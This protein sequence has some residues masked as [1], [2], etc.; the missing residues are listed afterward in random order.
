MVT[1]ACGGMGREIATSLARRGANV[2][3]VCRDLDRGL[4][5]RDAI[6][7][8]TGNSLVELLLADLSDQAAIHRIAAKFLERHDRLHVLI[9]NAGAHVMTRQLSVD[10][11]EMNLAVNHMSAFVLTD[12][13]LPT[14][15][16]SAPARIV[17]V[18]SRAMTKGIDLDNLNWDHDFAPW[19]AYGQAK[20]AM[21]LCSH[22]L[23]RELAITGVDINAV[24]PGLTATDIVDDIA[25]PRLRPILPIIKMCLLSPER[26]AQAALRLAC[27]ASL[28][29]TT[30]VHF[31]RRHRR[32]SVAAS[33]DIDLQNRTWQASAE[34]ATA[35]ASQT[36][37]N[38]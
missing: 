6:V 27:D 2:V 28:T 31:K 19:P 13:L 1:G 16:S 36:T 33:Y 32:N 7:D 34:L 14:I 30:G 15:K 8:T 12:L 38:P 29:G 10:G 20:L 22:R 21:V 25:S 26:G 11:V 9:N 17:N 18:A 35:K 4:A 37:E 3:M 5:A 23:A 24:H